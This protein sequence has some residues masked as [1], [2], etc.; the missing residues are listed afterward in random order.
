MERARVVGFVGLGEMGN[1]MAANLV[2]A[3]WRVV[4]FDVV[5][6]RLR[7]AQ[8]AGVQ[9]AGSCREVAR[10]A[11][12]IIVSIV[13]TFPQTETVLF[14]DEGLAAAHRPGLDVLIMSTLDPG[15]MADLAGRAA[16]QGM[17]LIDA[18]VSGGKAGAEAGT[19]SIMLAGPPEAIE[20]VRPVLECFGRHLFVLGG[21]PGTG[22]A[23]KL[24]NQ[25]MLS[26]A[27]L[28][29]AE[30]LTL[31]RAFG[32]DASQVLPII[33]A[34][35]GDSWA[36]QNWDIVRGWWERYTPGTNLDVLEKDLKSVAS[37][38]TRLQLQFPLSA[39]ALAALH[40]AWKEPLTGPAGPRVPGPTAGS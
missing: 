36:A 22:Q 9:T 18:P 12:G 17:T 13:R 8:C 23:A 21:R 11:D 40:S 31:A 16:P 6:E 19:L 26:A 30:G 1:P 14:G 39:A 37:A 20:R 3:G 2:K 29:V 32:L 15:A 4:A 24:A 7:A 34:S 28:G 33:A 27:M 38:A 25:I 10:A 5:A 35:T